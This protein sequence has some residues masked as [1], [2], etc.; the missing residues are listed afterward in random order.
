MFDFPSPALG[1]KKRIQAGDRVGII[2]PATTDIAHPGWK[3][4]YGDQL[5][6]QPC[7]ISQRLHTENACLTFGTQV[8]I[9]NRVL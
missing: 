4:R 6:I 8:V 3:I 9:L 1:A 7:E 5:I 2:F